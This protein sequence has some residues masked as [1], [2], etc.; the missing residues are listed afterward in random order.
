MEQKIFIIEDDPVIREQLQVLLQG[1]GY[2]TKAAL[3][4][5]DAASQVREYEPHLVL[6]DINCQVSVDFPSALR[7][8]VFLRFL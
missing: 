4:F 1:S 5:G 3:D 6:L 8:G 7:S 2:E